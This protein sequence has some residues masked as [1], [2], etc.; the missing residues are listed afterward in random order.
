MAKVNSNSLAKKYASQ[1]I[2]DDWE[3][4]I[5]KNKLRITPTTAV[6]TQEY[7]AY[8]LLLRL[9]EYNENSATPNE[10]AAFEA[11]VLTRLYTE[12]IAKAKTPTARKQ[13]Q[14]LMTKL[15]NDVTAQK[16]FAEFL[17]DGLT[18]NGLKVK[19]G[20]TRETS[21]KSKEYKTLLLLMK[22]RATANSLDRIKR[23]YV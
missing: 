1:F 6:G 14:D 11:L 9:R 19:L 12:T 4:A 21:Q 2:K 22:A 10:Y 23:V 18:L 5:L 13:G 3:L 20:V 7:Q 16:Y 15:E 17:S 8:Q